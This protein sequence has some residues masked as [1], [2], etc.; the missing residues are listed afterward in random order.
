[1]TVVPGQ[2]SMTAGFANV[3]AAPMLQPCACVA[4]TVTEG[5]Q[6]SIGTDASVT[7]TGNA[8]VAVFPAASVAVHVTTVVPGPND[9]P[10]G[11]EHTRFVPAQLSD[12][13]TL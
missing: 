10:E 4:A 8:H 5:G 3:T 1:M 6:D 9:D 7:T 12:A 11:G 13:E 2:F